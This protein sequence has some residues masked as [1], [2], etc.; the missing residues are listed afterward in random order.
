[1]GYY[2]PPELLTTPFEGGWFNL[3]AV[4]IVVM[5]SLVLVKGTSESALVNTI[6]VILKVAIVLVFI[7]V[8]LKYVDT[9]NHIP[10]IP[11][12][13][14]NFGEFVFSGI[15]RGA[16]IVFFAYIG[17]DAVSTAAQETKNPKKAM[18]KIGR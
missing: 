12:N 9:Q 1:Y 4:F 17:F 16:A 7:F 11:Q 13:T 6:I 10:F 8:G 14:G 2:L 3:P 18:Q 5:M 15:I